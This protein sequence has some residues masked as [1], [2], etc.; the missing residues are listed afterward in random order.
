[1]A[2]LSSG[3]A[4]LV[5]QA[6]EAEATGLGRTPFRAGA[7]P[8]FPGGALWAIQGPDACP[9]RSLV[10]SPDVED[11]E[12]MGPGLLEAWSPGLPNML[13]KCH[14]L[15]QLGFHAWL[16]GH[17]SSVPMA[18][19]R[20][21]PLEALAG[22]IRAAGHH[23]AIVCGASLLGWQAAATLA[24]A[25]VEVFRPALRALPSTR[26]RPVSPLGRKP[27]LLQLSLPPVP[28]SRKSKPTAGIWAA[29]LRHSTG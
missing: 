4:T 15:V 24:V 1:M 8:A 16:Q 19:V 23:S 29:P 7:F 9:L 22:R 6:L 18:L 11:P 26:W 12:P 3:A 14:A 21:G 10:G 27:S 25:G 13:Y 5:I 17:T 2:I 28:S 20:Q